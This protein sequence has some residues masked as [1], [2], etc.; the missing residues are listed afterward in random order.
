MNSR[1]F[2]AEDASV[3]EAI[4]H[5]RRDVRGNRFL[6]KEVGQDVLD[7]LL[8]AAMQAPSVGFSQPWE[9]VLIKDVGVRQQVREC[10]EAENDRAKELFRGDKQ[11][12]YNRLKLE[13]ITEAPINMAVFYSPAEGPVL[14]QTSM[15]EVGLYSVVCAI[16]NLWL[17]ARALNIGVG[18]VSILQEEKVKQILNAPSQNRLIAYLCIGYVDTFLA[19]PEL[20]QLGWEKRKEKTA[21]VF[22]DR[23]QSKLPANEGD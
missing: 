8:A 22:Y 15:K 9:F 13:G 17:M 19:S 20:E 23:Y 21:A 18:W 3:L 4:I 1:I 10:F 2:T 11:E 6:P 14:G 5:H 7:K 16:Q 12:L